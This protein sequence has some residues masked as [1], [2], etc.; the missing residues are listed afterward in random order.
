MKPTARM[1]SILL[2]VVLCVTA[3]P[4]A[5]F[6]EPVKSIRMNRRRYTLAKGNSVQLDVTYNPD[7]AT[8]GLE[9]T[10][11]SSDGNVAEVDDSGYVTAVGSGQCTIKARTSNGKSTTC[12]IRVPGKVSPED[13]EWLEEE[14]E[15]GYLPT[16]RLTGDKL[17][18][19]TLKKNLKAAGGKKLTLRNIRSVDADTLRSAGSGITYYFDTR[20][21]D[22]TVARLSFTS[23]TVGKLSGEI[24]L[25]VY[26]GTRNVKELEIKLNKYFANTFNIIRCEQASFGTPVQFAIRANELETSD[27]H[28]YS[29]NSKTGKYKLMG[30]K[31]TVDK[32][33]YVH[34]TTSQG[35][36][37]ILSDGKLKKK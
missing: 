19:D 4:F 8:E 25:G 29:Y 17:P 18:L 2:A 26:C 21:G 6:A 33:G 13:S 28:L 34:F 14:L 15:D 16:V 1:L 37:M 24:K 31:L 5:I 12:E 3:I 32:N 22:K 30:T 7:D 27:L 20:S 9:I 10:W 23:E 36:Y 11:S 35:G